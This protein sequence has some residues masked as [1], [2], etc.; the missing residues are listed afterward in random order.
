MRKGAA[1]EA[2]KAYYD[3]QVFRPEE[4]VKQAN[5]RGRYAIVNIEEYEK[6]HAALKLITELEKG[7]I[8]G[9]QEGWFTMEEIKREFDGSRA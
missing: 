2:V 6:A 3:G 9:E 1:M 5:G 4:S 8:S 7:R